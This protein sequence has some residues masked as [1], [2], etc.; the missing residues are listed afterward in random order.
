MKTTCLHVA[1]LAL[2]ISCR[3]SNASEGTPAPGDAAPFARPPVIETVEPIWNAGR[4]G[5]WQDF[6]WSPHADL[7]NGPARLNVS[8]WGGW[9]LARPGLSGDFGG[10]VFR[11]KAPKSFGDFLEVHVESASKRDFPRLRPPAQDSKDVGDGYREYFISMSALSPD[12]APFDRI[13]FF[14]TRALPSDLVAFDQI[15]LTKARDP[16]TLPPP[17]VRDHAMTV[18]CRARPI[19]INAMIYGIAFDPQHDAR[20]TQQWTIGATARRWGGNPSSRYNWQL[21]NAWNTASD[22]YFE[23]TNYTASADYS[24]RRFL[25]D[26]AAHGMK[27]ALTVPILGWVA[28]DTTSYSFPFSVSGPQQSVDPFRNDAAN[29]KTKDGKDLSPGPASRTSV[30]APPEF[31]RRWVE[32]IRR[33]EAGGGAR[34]VHQYILDNEPALWSSTHRD[35]HPEPLGYDE[36]VARTIQYGAAIRS[37]DPAAVI[38]GPAEWGWPNYFFSAR[39]AVAGFAQ[40]PDRRAHGD[41]PLMAWYLRKL[42]EHERDTGVRVLDVVDLHFYPQGERL[43]GAN[44]G[45]DPDAARRRVRASRALWDPTYVDE[46]WIKEPV[47]LFPRMKEWIA[48][49]YPGRGISLG[50]WSFGGEGHIS[51]ALAV[52]ESLGRFAEAG[53]TSAFY[54]SY[55]PANSPVFWAFRAYTNFDGRGGRFQD[56]FVSASSATTSLTSLFASRDDAAS[57][58]VL[59]ALNAAPDSAARATIALPG[60]DAPTA[61]SS[62]VYVGGGSGIAEGAPVRAAAGAIIAELPPSSITVIDLRMRAASPLR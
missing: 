50:E 1:C 22:W 61:A 31:V 46:S 40:K 38:A 41:V 5:G 33:A 29:G 34:Q 53:L 11:M 10:L 18:D 26:N 24:Y 14:V 36:L 60:C 7:P 28:K 43:Y 42:F 58:F 49:N 21:G 23:N 45:T 57:R 55:P 12:G 48:Q 16:A 9:I 32:T 20:D 6:G 2:T 25:A 17:P 27:T 47:R 39:D 19:K 54:W 4:K 51:G 35:V 44:G 37:A 59:V 3:N 62:W 8:S 15:G 30:A 56:N 52:A 13:V